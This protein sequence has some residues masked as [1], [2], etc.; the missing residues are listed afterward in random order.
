[1]HAGLLV[2]VVHDNHFIFFVF[3][4]KAVQS[5]KWKGGTCPGSGKCLGS[6]KLRGYDTFDNHLVLSGRIGYIVNSSILFK[7]CNVATLLRV[8]TH[9][10]CKSS[11]LR[12]LGH[13]SEV[14]HI[15][16]EVVQAYLFH[17]LVEVVDALGVG[18]R[19][20]QARQRGRLEPAE[21]LAFPFCK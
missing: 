3:L 11:L 6:S 13:G 17:F 19:G 15:V 16:F 4:L 14:R 10:F 12:F 1:M 21:V 9:G 7:Y 2:H 5:Y 8:Q 18:V 20:D